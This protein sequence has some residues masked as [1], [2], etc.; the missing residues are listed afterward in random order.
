MTQTHSVF[1]WWEKLLEADFTISA[2]EDVEMMVTT[3]MMVACK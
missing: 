1:L 3:R 2:V